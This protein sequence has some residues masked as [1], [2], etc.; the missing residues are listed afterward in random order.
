MEEIEN[1]GAAAYSASNIQVL[2]GLE[3]VRKRPLCTLATSVKKVCT[4]WCTR[5]S[6][7]PLTK[8]LRVLYTH[9]SNH[10]S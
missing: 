9:R 4:T 10:L 8:P 3:A 1:K 5:P 6:T 7:T 2:E